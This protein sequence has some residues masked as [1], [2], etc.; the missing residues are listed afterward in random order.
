MYSFPSVSVAIRT[1]VPPESAYLS[2][3]ETD[4]ASAVALE[5]EGITDSANP[6]IS[7]IESAF[8]IP[9]PASI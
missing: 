7:P 5:S 4:G 6:I 9:Y 2:T 8:F 3:T 1:G